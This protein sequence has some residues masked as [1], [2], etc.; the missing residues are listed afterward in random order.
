MTSIGGQAFSGCTGLKDIVIPE[1]VTSIGGW[2]FSGCT[3]LQSVVFEN[4]EGWRYARSGDEI[5]S[6][7][8]SDPASAARILSGLNVINGGIEREKHI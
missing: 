1:S 4:P 6:E 2:A 5:S 7:D 8:L 3:A